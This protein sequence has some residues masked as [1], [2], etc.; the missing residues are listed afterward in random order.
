M[1][2]SRRAR[3][4]ARTGVA[5]AAALGAA[6]SAALAAGV[7]TGAQAA[8]WV[9]ESA[10]SIV[11][12]ASSAPVEPAAVMDAAGRG[13]AAW[14]KDGGSGFRLQFATRDAGG[15]WTTGATPLAS[16][17]NPDI[18]ASDLHLV[19][20]S[21]GLVTAVWLQSGPAGE[22]VYVADRP[23]GG[24]WSS[25]ISIS[26]DDQNAMELQ[27][28]VNDQ[29]S[30]SAVWTSY[31]GGVSS[32]VQ[33]VKR[34]A[35]TT[36][37][38]RPVKRVSALTTEA[39][40]PVLA[41]GGGRFA[42]SWTVQG[43]GS[44]PDTVWTAQL[45]AGDNDWSQVSERT[46][47]RPTADASAQ[48]VAVDAGGDMSVL[49]REDESNEGRMVAATRA[50]NE[51]WGT[52][53]QLSGSGRDA[54][55]G[56]LAVNDSGD[57]LATWNRRAGSYLQVQT[58][59]HQPSNDTWVSPSDLD[60]AVGTADGDAFPQD[61][62]VDDAG[63]P[64]V[65]VGTATGSSQTFRRTV[66][67]GTEVWNKIE[68]AQPAV[69]V[70][71]A[72]DAAGDVASYSL[73]FTGGDQELVERVFDAS[74]PT[75]TVTALPSV[76]RAKTYPVSWSGK[77][78]WSALTSYDVRVRSAAWNSDFEP[79]STSW[80][81]LATGTTATYTPKAGQT[82]CFTATATDAAGNTGLPSDE[83]CST[84]PVDDRTMT[85]SRGW[86]SASSGSSI[87][88]R[89]TLTQSKTKYAK[90]T[91]PNVK[92]STLQLYALGGR[93]YGSIRVSHAGRTIG[94][95]SLSRSR[96]VPVTITL[97]NVPTTET[98]SVVVMV[99]SS[100]KWVRIDGLAAHKLP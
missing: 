100:R 78:V 5:V 56:R 96:T 49:W 46:K 25:P 10:K 84:S 45:S 50:L 42:A 81:P 76:N 55:L 51:E 53:Q 14:F 18:S 65:L 37:S 47:L 62:L 82:S 69:A 98:G 22:D 58:I 12:P 16:T 13:T 85:R 33:G 88:Y 31:V 60:S 61:A 43:A 48:S 99:T 17:S 38:S 59:W 75:A 70:T 24:S 41:G 44:D 97:R 77:D 39:T 86:A 71:L 26:D 83:V 4:R 74:A 8:D 87:V 29:R 92:A 72:Q 32:Q 94:S 89:G 30:V 19:V 34:E 27:L 20:D 54:Q 68:N 57:L 40:H 23:A 6:C 28:A 11:A 15:A 79:A 7:G 3:S 35:G 21:D 91:L 9:A 66:Q 93:G 2:A 36:W 95:W 1:P 90:L 73:R 67:D 52:S 64:T 80:L 63:V